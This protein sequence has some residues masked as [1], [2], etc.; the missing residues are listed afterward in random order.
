MNKGISRRRLLRNTLAVG[1]STA[2]SPLITPLTFASAPTGSRLVVIILRGAMDG[3]DVVQPYGDR[4]LRRLRPGF[5]TGPAGG[6]H[7]LDGFFALHP[8]LGDLKPLW[9]A[10]ELGFAHAVSTP[11]R[12]KRSHFDGQDFLEN[13]GSAR[14][15][16]LTGRHDG[17][18]NRAL[19]LI[20]GATSHT[21]Y[22]VGRNRMLLLDGA[23]P[24]SSWSPD[25][26]LDLPPGALSAIDRLY[27]ADPLFRN[28]AQSAI[29][30]SATATGRM[31]ARAAARAGALAE[32]AAA[33]LNEDARIAA[34]SIGGWDTHR[35]QKGALP[36]ALKELSSAI[37]ALN[38][39]LGRNWRRT[40]VLAMTEFGRTARENG[41]G[42]TDHGTG[43]AMILAGG[44]IRGGKVYGRWPGLGG[45]DL[46]EG[47]D[48]NPTGDVRRYSAWALRA[49]FGLGR[50]GIEGRVFPRLDMGGDPGI[51]A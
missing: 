18:L 32:Y 43:G 20:P 7:D 23:A 46:Y 27:A 17:W 50:S 29:E 48:L 28:A 19:G 30:L 44:A 38:R 16:R 8:A 21:A 22:A 24:Y 37:V 31:N 13:G 11:Y 12:N 14:D 47:R 6:A 2:A 45:G 10:G 33:R 3:L 1:C 36:I 15:G 41:S 9:K 5:A 4:N 25:G 34:F 40:A 35:A 49:L 39:K 51:I 42:G 26:E